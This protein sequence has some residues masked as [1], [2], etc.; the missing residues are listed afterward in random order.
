MENHNYSLPARSRRQPDVR[1]PNWIEGATN[2]EEIEARVLIAKIANL[3]D[4]GL[5]IEAVVVDFVFK[6]IQPLKDRVHPTYV[7]TGIRDVLNGVEMMPRGFIVN[8]GAPRSYSTSNLPP[9]VSS[10]HLISHCHSLYCCVLHADSIASLLQS[11]FTE[12]VSNLP[13]REEGS[14]SSHRV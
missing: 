4:R 10:D 2:S 6:N 7:S 9:P 11:S 13:I 5:T 12:F 14:G 1:I 8:D 3:K